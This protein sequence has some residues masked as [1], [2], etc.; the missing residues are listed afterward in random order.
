[1]RLY[2][3][4]LNIIKD[5]LYEIYVCISHS[6][7]GDQFAIT[8]YLM[9]LDRTTVYTLGQALGLSQWKV[10]HMMASEIFLDKVISAWLRREDHVEKIGMPTWRTLVKALRHPRIGQN[11]LANDISRDKGL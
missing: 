4:V 10:E 8:T 6:D 1:M 5:W 7:E 2:I 9:S 3:T 11:G